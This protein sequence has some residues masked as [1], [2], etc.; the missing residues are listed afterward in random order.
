MIITLVSLTSRDVMGPQ[1]IVTS[2]LVSSISEPH[3][4]TLFTFV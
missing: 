2:R 1:K 3:P 4:L